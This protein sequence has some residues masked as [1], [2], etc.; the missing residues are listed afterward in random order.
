MIRPHSV[1]IGTK[2]GRPKNE[3]R[4]YMRELYGEWSDRTFARYWSCM[5]NVMPV[6]R[7]V[8]DDER[9]VWLGIVAKCTR[10]NG[11]VN[12]TELQRQTDIYIVDAIVR[13]PSIV[14]EHIDCGVFA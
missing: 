3:F 8:G 1:P 12:V 2:V 6:A 11:S 4:Q 7:H 14:E 9:A 10:A 5:S 13:C